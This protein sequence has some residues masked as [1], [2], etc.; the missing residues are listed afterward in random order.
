MST[1]SSPPSST[2]VD[3]SW[4]PEVTQGCGSNI[5]QGSGSDAPRGSIDIAPFQG[6]QCKPNLDWVSLSWFCFSSR[7]SGT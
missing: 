7:K 6:K 1:Q 4:G 3:A 2:A 5:A